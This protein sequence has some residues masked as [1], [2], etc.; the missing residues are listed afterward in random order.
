MKFIDVSHVVEHGML[1]Y[2]G[3]PAPT[4][5]DYLSRET[6]RSQYADGTTFQIGKIDMVAN[7]GTYID[8][9]FHRYAQGKDLSELN[10]ASLAYLD[11]IVFRTNPAPREVCPEIFEGS[12]L[13]GKAVLIHTGWDKYWRTD[14]YFENHPFLTEASARHLTASGVSLVGIDSL[15][16]DD[17]ADPGRPA[18]SILLGA[19]IPILE[20]LCNLGA[21][22]D[23]GFKF[24]A[25]PVKVKGLGS[26]PVRAFGLVE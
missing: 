25:V 2:K 13:Q 21:L 19:D 23:R 17:T 16:I 9:P 12:E 18:H 22:P 6:S 8:A 1:T 26:F 24:F 3:L 14:S 20:H 4:I 7:T 5:S 11:G 10:L 15:N